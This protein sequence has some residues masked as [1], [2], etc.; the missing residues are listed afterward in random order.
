M[1]NPQK[2]RSKFSFISYPFFGTYKVPDVRVDFDKVTAA[3]TTR[4]STVK[5]SNSP[6]YLDELLN[7]ETNENEIRFRFQVTAKSTQELIMLED[8]CVWGVDRTGRMHNLKRYEE[9]EQFCMRPLKI[10][11]GKYL[12]FRGITRPIETPLSIKNI[13]ED[14]MYYW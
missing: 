11:Q 14:L 1:S 2:L 9:F 4:Y 12:W 3:I 6:N 13:A 10:T 5:L 8:R 7:L